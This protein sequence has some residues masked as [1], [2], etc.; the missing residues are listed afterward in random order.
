MPIKFVA[1]RIKRFFVYR[2]L[3]LD[4]TPHRI[5]LGV[6]IGIFVTWTPTIG[7]QMVLAVALSLLLRANKFVGVPFV[8]LSNPFTVV[9][10]Y[11]PSYM[12][13][14]HM[15]GGKYTWSAFTG[16]IAEASQYDGGLID[17]MCAWLTATLPIIAPLWLGSVV[18][19]LA[20]A[21]VTYPAIYWGVGA[22]RRHRSLTHP[23]DLR[24]DKKSQ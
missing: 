10:I 3:S 24:Q 23:A 17:K 12:L 2:V 5:A 7:L 6:A 19:G 4:D 18:V 15:L 21:L 13:G 11:G 8:W 16:A 9:P 20:L 22:Y 1:K 14:S